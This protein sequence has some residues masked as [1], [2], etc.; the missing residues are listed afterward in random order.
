MQ[1]FLFAATKA[2][3]KAGN[4]YT[5]Q[6]AQII[7]APA[8]PDAFD[9]IFVNEGEEPLEPGLYEADIYV[10]STPTGNKVAFQNFVKVD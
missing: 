5:Y 3:S 2:V 10:R 8:R 7:Q 6:P 9:R 4:A 1:I